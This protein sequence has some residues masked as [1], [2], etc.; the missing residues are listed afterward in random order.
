MSQ[1]LHLAVAEL[2]ASCFAD[3][4]KEIRRLLS[5]RAGS[6]SD[7]QSRGVRVNAGFTDCFDTLHF[8]VE[9]ATGL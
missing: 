7:L 1:E 5:G 6:V 9:A 4:Q 8:T 2:C 3:L